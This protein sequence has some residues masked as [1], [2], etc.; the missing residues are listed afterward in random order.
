[1]TISLRIYFTLTL[2]SNSS[3]SKSPG[4]G[5]NVFGYL[6][7]FLGTHV[8]GPGEQHLRGLWCVLEG[9]SHPE[10]PCGAQNRNDI[11]TWGTLTPSI[12]HTQELFFP[13]CD[14]S[15]RWAFKEMDTLYPSYPLHTEMGS[16]VDPLN[17]ITCNHIRCNMYGPK[18]WK[19]TGTSQSTH[20][21]AGEL[22]MLMAFRSS[23]RNNPI[24]LTYMDHFINISHLSLFSKG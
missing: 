6:K 10:I 9:N 15:L 22:R 12:W 8:P 20:T 21:K 7:C 4:E 5:S 17:H 1:M 16:P 14:R 2:F 3:L 11:Q 19:G 13:Q 24:F 23:G 18:K